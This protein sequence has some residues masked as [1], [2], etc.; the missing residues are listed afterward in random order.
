[1]DP[2]ALVVA[3]LRPGTGPLCGGARHDDTAP[4]TR[5]GRDSA[6]APPGLVVV[7]AVGRGSGGGGPAGGGGAGRAAT[8][9][10]V[11]PLV[12][13]SAVPAVVLGGGGGYRVDGVARPARAP[14][15]HPGR[16]PAAGRPGG[17]HRLCKQRDGPV[18]ADRRVR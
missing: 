7:A 10:R 11:D 4:W 16:A 8:A 6:A 5:S 2:G 1:M 17:R 12:H 18:A 15:P 14:D 9:R 3:A 13:P